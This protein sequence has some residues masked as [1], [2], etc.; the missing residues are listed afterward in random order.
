MHRLLV[1]V[2]AMTLFSGCIGEDAIPLDSGDALFDAALD[3][4]DAAAARDSTTTIID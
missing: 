2:M 3:S 4:G 1:V